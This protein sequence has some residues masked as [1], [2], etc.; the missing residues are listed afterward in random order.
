MEANKPFL[1]VDSIVVLGSQHPLPKHPKKLLPKL[2]PDNDV[3]LEDHIKQFML[4]RRL[5][6]VHHEDVACRLFLYTFIENASTWF[7]NLTTRSITSWKQ[8]ET[9]FLT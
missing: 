4:Y 1:I 3:T 6:D 9:A 2:D 8:F 5:M 7:F